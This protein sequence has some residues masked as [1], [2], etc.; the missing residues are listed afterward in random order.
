MHLRVGDKV[1]H[2]FNANICGEVVELKEVNDRSMSTGGSFTPKRYAL[3]ENKKG[4][5][6]WI[7]FDNI[8]KDA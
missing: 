1:R 7:S 8:M 4:D 6:T 3:V 2:I 5:Q